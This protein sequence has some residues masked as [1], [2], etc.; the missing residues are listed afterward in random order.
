[1]TVAKQDSDV[2][3]LLNLGLT[4]P[5]RTQ[6]V[7]HAVADEMR[8]ESPDTLVLC[9]PCSPYLC[10][11]YHQVYDRTV[12]R[13]EPARLGLP[14]F[15]RRV[16]GGLTYL[17]SNQLFYQCVFH[18]S[19]VPPLSKDLYQTMLTAPVGAL[20]R[21]GLDARL[22]FE[23]EIEVDGKRIAGIGGARIGEASV[24]V[25]NILF[26]FAEEPLA[27]V[28]RT[29]SESFRELAL[30]ALR[31]QI[32]T[33]RQLLGEIS[34]EALEG[35]LLDEFARA[36][37]RPLEAGALTRAE[38]QRSRELGEQMSSPEYLNLHQE[39]EAAAPMKGLKIS[40]RVSIRAGEVEVAGRRLRA[41]FR[42]RGDVIEEARLECDSEERWAAMETELQGVPFREWESYLSRCLADAPA[43]MARHV[44]RP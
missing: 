23:N 41:S 25:G 39:S 12:D 9:R 15:R 27:R 38:E 35:I 4:E 40:A 30:S 7:Y 26:D 37:C 1:M 24:V 2:V 21:L 36:W 33:L 31:E 44:G 13:R 10:L 32:V 11:G 8:R 28:W 20:R 42:V 34:V 29:P 22:R 19:R 43:P 14:V 3:R 16:G 17:D 18:Q 5:W 6:A